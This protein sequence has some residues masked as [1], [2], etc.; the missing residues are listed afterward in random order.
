M[1][2]IMFNSIATIRILPINRALHTKITLLAKQL[3][4]YKLFMFYVKKTRRK[5]HFLK[6]DREKLANWSTS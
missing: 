1:I 2:N 5:R 3:F 4:N 6:I